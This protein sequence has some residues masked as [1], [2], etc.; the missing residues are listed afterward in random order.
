MSPGR[1]KGGKPD[2]VTRE[3]DQIDVGK[4]PLEDARERAQNA[5]TTDEE[6]VA[7]LDQLIALLED[8]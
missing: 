4:R 8:S 5:T 3:G 6:I 1:D 2:H 7:K